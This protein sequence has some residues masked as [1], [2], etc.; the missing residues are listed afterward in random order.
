[1]SHEQ[2]RLNYFVFHHIPHKLQPLDVMSFHLLKGNLAKVSQRLGFQ[3]G[4]KLPLFIKYA[5]SMLSQF[6]ITLSFRIT[7]IIPVNPS[8]SKTFKQSLNDGP[9]SSSANESLVELGII[10]AEL[11]DILVQVPVPGTPGTRH[12]IGGARHIT[13]NQPSSD[14]DTEDIYSSL[15]NRHNPIDSPDTEHPNDGICVVRMTNQRMDV[16]IINA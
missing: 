16:N 6:D 15:Q 13:G 10:P 11:S 7:G 8:V 12:R 9:R 1:M 2:K 3:L 4:G 14:D 5:L